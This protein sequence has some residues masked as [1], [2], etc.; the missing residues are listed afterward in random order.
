MT[1]NTLLM[2]LK[3]RKFWIPPKLTGFRPIEV[4]KAIQ[5]MK[6]RFDYLEE[7]TPNEFHLETT[8][9]IL[10]DEWQA[11]G[12]LSEVLNVHIK[13]APYALFGLRDGKEL[14][15]NQRF[16][17]AYTN[18]LFSKPLKLPILALLRAFLLYYPSELPTF[19]KIRTDLERLLKT[20]VF[21]TGARERCEN[22]HLL[23]QDAPLMWAV[24]LMEPHP[25]KLLKDAGLTGE[26][27]KGSFVRSAVTHLVSRVEDSLRRNDVNTNQAL[28]NL[29]TVAVDEGSLRFPEGRG[30]LAEGLL[31]PFTHKT[32][33]EEIKNEISKFL[34]KHLRDPRLRPDQWIGV[35]KDAV[36]VLKRWLVG[37]TLEDFFFILD[38]S[39]LDQ[40]WF[41]RRA[42]W[43]AYWRRG[44][45]QEAWV[46]LGTRAQEI[47]RR[48][49]RD[50]LGQ[51]A[52]LKGGQSTHSVLLMQIGD[53]TVAEWSH[54][55]AC[56]FWDSR[57]W[58]PELYKPVYSSFQL[59]KL[60]GADEAFSHHGSPQ[61]R[62]QYQFEHYI[63]QH[64]GFSVPR[65]E[66]MP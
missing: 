54:S 11:T 43:H 29:F 56:R 51:Y 19:N 35:D 44:Y 18:R 47:V 6:Q 10:Q 15:G 33:P 27:A 45:I 26:L 57:E 2:A 13:R 24:A 31:L 25:M 40:H 63:S 20:S 1:G 28:Q 4:T 16:W 5:A 39:A 48:R 12:A 61:G 36:A 8:L 66:Y 50:L 30:R 21:L 46:A 53:L 55:G 59:K 37:D 49:R 3:Q 62:W 32:P 58:A 22:H 65:N 34:V 42:F 41:Y 17:E 60:G 9:K 38:Q 23:H 52:Q 7:A 14:A 64:T